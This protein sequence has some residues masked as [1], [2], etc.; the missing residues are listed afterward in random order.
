MRIHECLDIVEES[1]GS[2][3]ACRKCNQHLGA[4][5]GNDKAACLYSSIDKDQLTE[6]PPPGGRHSMGRYIAYYCPGGVTLPEVEVPSVA[7]AAPEPVWDIRIASHAVA[8]AGERVR[9]ETSVDGEQAN[10][11]IDAVARS[12]QRSCRNYGFGTRRHPR[13]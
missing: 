4:A 13:G 7:G 11:G 1:E 8:K 5:D 3:I 10:F 6:L 12:S 2:V 9:S